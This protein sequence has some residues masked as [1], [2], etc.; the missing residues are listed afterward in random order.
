[1]IVTEINDWKTSKLAQLYNINN[2]I[3]ADDRVLISQ[4][5]KKNQ[6][7]INVPINVVYSVAAKSYKNGFTP[8]KGKEKL[9]LLKTYKLYIALSFFKDQH[10]SGIRI[11]AEHYFPK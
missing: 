4:T 9:R 1:M 10:C 8:N 6:S 5:L 2:M 7:I 3:W 11:T